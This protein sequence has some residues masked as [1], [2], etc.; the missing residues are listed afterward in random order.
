[1]VRMSQSL[2]GRDIGS[3]AGQGTAHATQLVMGNPGEKALLIEEAQRLPA[4][5]LARLRQ[6][7]KIDMG[8]DVLEPRITEKVIAPAVLSVSRQGPARAE[9]SIVE[10]GGKPVVESKHIPTLEDGSDLAHPATSG[11]MHLGGIA[12][13]RGQRQLFEG[14]SNDRI[15]NLL[16]GPRKILPSENEAPLLPMTLPVNEALNRE[17]IDEFVGEEDTDGLTRGQIGCAMNPD[18][19]GGQA[20]P[21]ESLVLT[22]AL[23]WKFFENDVVEG[24]EKIGRLISHPSKDV[25]G[26]LGIFGALLNDGKDGWLFQEFPHLQ[27]LPS[28]E[29]A[30]ERT[31]ADAGKE[32]TFPTGSRRGRL[33]AVVPVLGMVE[34]EI[35]KTAERHRTVPSDFFA[36]ERSERSHAQRVMQE[37]RW[38]EVG[39]GGELIARVEHLIDQHRIR[40]FMAGILRYDNGVTTEALTT[41]ADATSPTLRPE[42]G[43]GALHLFYRVN[44]G[45]WQARS[46]AQRAEALAHLEEIV[47][48]ARHR[49]QTQVLTFAMFTRADL[50][51]MILTPD[52]HELNALEKKLTASLGPGVFVPEFTYLSMTEKS[53]YTQSE[54]EYALT[55]EKSERVMRGTPESDAMV[56]KFRE[57]IQHYRHDRMYPVLPEWEYFCFYPMSKRR[58]PGQNWYALGFERRRELMAGHMTVGRTYAGRVR[59]LIT[60]STGLDDWEWGVSL[61]AHDPLQIKAIVYEM[62]FDEVSHDYGEFGPFYNGLPMTLKEIYRR[63]LLS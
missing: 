5:R 10:R 41:P 51:F 22:R 13:D 55:L 63:L 20:D 16:G 49:P 35:H 57:R 42:E 8:R 11:E 39:G 21:I 37:E 48:A 43:L 34:R 6:P 38:S 50:G 14:F 30:E 4:R 44:L 17:G 40:H 36:D 7:R 29:A 18:D 32:V 53:E 61:F 45:L 59:Q 62:R 46:E 12:F 28:E 24:S 19:L 47:E 31:D 27:E 26:E 33:A 23:R 54:E 1:M 15:V 60:G 3:N 52:L 2:P 58:V 56:T 9:G 25:A